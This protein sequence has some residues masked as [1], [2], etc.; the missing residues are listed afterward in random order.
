M[1]SPCSP[2]ILGA[3]PV[4]LKWNIV[5]GDTSPLRIEFYEN[6][7][8]TPFD[9][10]GWTFLSTAYDF[11]GD[12]LDELDVTVGEGYV[13]IKASSDITALWG[14]GYNRVVAELA[15]DLQ[16]TVDGDTVWTPVIGTISVLGDVTGGSL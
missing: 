6:D 12:I 5:R 16:V 4:I 7:E 3:D 8:K 14:T 2:E 15:F 11:K 10:T 1:T 9:M 13:E